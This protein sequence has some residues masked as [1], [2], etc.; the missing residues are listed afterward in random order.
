MLMLAPEKFPHG[1]TLIGRDSVSDL[2]GAR[3]AIFW[4]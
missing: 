3:Q 2:S 4:L 1:G